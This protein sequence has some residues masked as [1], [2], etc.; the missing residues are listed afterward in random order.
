MATQGAF[1]LS[2]NAFFASHAIRRLKRGTYYLFSEGLNHYYIFT[3]KGGQREKSRA[4]GGER[5][6]YLV[7]NQI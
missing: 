7:E 1:C 4:R 2:I 3:S 6:V 5:D